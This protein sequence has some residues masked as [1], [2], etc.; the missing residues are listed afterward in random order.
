VAVVGFDDIAM[1]AHFNP[2][3]TTMRQDI[4]RGARMLVDMLFRRL[5]GEATPSATM[6]AELIV[7]ESSAAPANARGGKSSG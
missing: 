2:T 6:P 5:N 1:A 7:R 4:A 3:L